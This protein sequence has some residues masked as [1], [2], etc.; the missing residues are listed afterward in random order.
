MASGV[1]PV[2]SDSGEIPHVIG[3]AG[4]IFRQGNVDD[5]TEKLR[6][7]IDQPDLHATL[8]QRGRERVLAH[9]TQRALA[10][11]YYDVYQEML[12]RG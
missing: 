6:L 5:L 8:A 7:L 9:Y 10:R 11:A 2:G 3:D 4:L 1:P 12:D